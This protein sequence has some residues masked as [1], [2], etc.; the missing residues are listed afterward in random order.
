MSRLVTLAAVTLSTAVAVPAALA[1][2]TPKF[3]YGKPDEVKDV[4]QT[5]WNA[6]AEAGLVFTT[7]NSRTTTVS[8]GAK[9]T[10]KQKQ[11]KFSLDASGT[12][13]RAS[14]LVADDIGGDKILSSNEVKREDKT[15]AQSYQIKLR[16][17]RFLSEFNSLFVAALGGADVIAG[18]DFAGGG[19]LGYARLL[20]KTERHEVTAELGYDFSYEDYVDPAADALAIHSARGF[21]GYKGKLSEVTSVDGSL[22]VLANVN[23]QSATV[24]PFEDLRA[25]ATASLSTKLTKSVSFQFGVIG[26]FDNAPAPL[27]IAG[28]M[29]NPLDPPSALKLDTTTKASLI[30]NFL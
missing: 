20:Y 9:A 27:S 4:K 13:A 29:L 22:E 25:N 5:E 1:Q 3:E 30:V 26:K 28:Y 16:Y 23:E 18:K 12:L 24:G 10:R 7:G 6:S 19:Q 11:N 15:S 17:D 21:L 8:A 14:N 2:P